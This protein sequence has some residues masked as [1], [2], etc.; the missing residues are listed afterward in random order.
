MEGPTV[1]NSIP[2]TNTYSRYRIPSSSTATTMT[3]A[4][5]ASEEEP[6]ADYKRSYTMDNFNQLGYFSSAD[7]IHP[8]L[9]PSAAIRDRYYQSTRYLQTHGDVDEEDTVYEEDTI[10][11]DILDYRPGQSEVCI[12]EP[13]VYSLNDSIISLHTE[14]NG[15]NND[16]ASSIT[17]IRTLDDRLQG[18]SRAS[19]LNQFAVK[20]AKK[21][22]RSGSLFR[23]NVDDK[24]LEPFVPVRD[25]FSRTDNSSS[26]TMGGMSLL[27]KLSKSTAPMRAKLSAISSFSSKN[28]LTG[29]KRMAESVYNMPVSVPSSIISRPLY[30]TR[31]NSDKSSI[32]HFPRSLSAS[33][34]TSSTSTANMIVSSAL[35]EEPMPIL[36]EHF[37]KIYP[38]FLSKVAEAFR[39]A[40]ELSTKTKDGIKYT[41][42][43]DGK[44]AVDKLSGLIKSNDRNLAILLGRALDSQKFFHDVNYEHR[45]RDSS[46][47]IYCFQE[48]IG[49]FVPS[50]AKEEEVLALPTGVFTLLTDCYSP[51]CTRE[52]LCYSSR[53]PRRQEQTKH[54]RRGHSREGSFSHLVMH[55]ERL[56]IHDVPVEILDTLSKDEKK[57]QENIFEL[58][59]TESDFVEDM[60]YILDYWVDPLL[61]EA[62]P[63]T[64][65]RQRLVETIFWN[66]NQVYTVNHRFSQALL[67]RQAESKVVD[68]IG[69]LLL[70]H[71]DFFEPFVRY[72]AHQLIGKYAFETEKSTNPSFADFVNQ[73]ERLPQSR[74]LELNG[75][76]TKPTTRLGRYNL[77]LREI[78]K[79]TA[80]AHPDQKYIPEVM[81][82]ITKFLSDVNR[83]TGVTENKFE[84]ERLDKRLVNRHISNLDLDLL[85]ENRQIVMK[86]TWKKGSGS[87]SSDVIVYLLDHCLLILKPKQNEER[88]KLYRKPIPLALLSISFPDQ[89]KRGSTI[90]TLGRPSTASSAGSIE[91]SQSHSSIVSTAASVIHQSSKS[92]FPVSFV[93]LGRQSSGSMTLYAPSSTVRKQ[94]S[95]KIEGQRKV[96]VEK[97]RVFNIKSINHSFFSSFNKVNCIAVFDNGQSFVL[98]GDQ[99]V[100]LKK[101]GDLGDSL[102]RI[103]TMEKVSQIDVLEQSN[104]ILVLADKILY[105]YSLDTLLPTETGMKRGRKLSS[106]VSFF[107]VGKIWDKSAAAMASTEEEKDDINGIE[108]TLVCFVRYSAMTSTI[109]ALE[110]CENTESKK[111]HKNLNRL[112]RGNNEALKVYKDLYIPGEASS[113][114]FFKNIICV[115]SARG[116]QM[117]NLSSA[118][119]QSVLDPND[120]NNNSLLAQHEYIKPISMFRHKNGDILLCYNELAFYID[121]KGKRVRKDWCITWEGHPTAFCFKFPYVVAFN[122]NFIEVR[123]IDTGDLLQVISGTN[124]RC[125][126]PDSTEIIH[127]VMDDRVG[128]NE[129]VF[130]LDLFEASRRK[131]S[132]IKN[133]Q[134]A[135]RQH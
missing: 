18:K 97:H 42:V 80:K 16:D 122:T 76:L 13:S 21:V 54:V 96:L 37:Y 7:I 49:A 11:G 24:K 85:S 27:S 65:D 73:T 86:G 81:A 130:E 133:V 95:D 53:C 35:V 34:S 72:G 38:A 94:W 36:R 101:G 9:T 113:I 125:L 43:F 66:L 119:V 107:K 99:G 41:N 129:V 123:H 14:Y 102:T 88:Y 98:G 56:W 128:G 100:Y 74:K 68:K 48:N 31:I 39:D 92:G 52:K 6:T 134:R 67:E 114:Q 32:H 79:H 71:V 2:S 131:Q 15:S 46:Q 57:R 83:E 28:N 69:D 93:H 23:R 121:K 1:K 51:T 40:I 77:L 8:E 132:M 90:I 135:I 89:N 106:H 109:R 117:V 45:L 20:T 126:R 33:S 111:K 25:S 55:E 127:G 84:L 70:S 4:S 87:E 108:R 63:V 26:K 104:L 82:K 5:F 64:G 44:E 110:P 120:D 58:I 78:L 22:S 19:Q 115:G 62:S 60:K 105:T 30:P 12:K 29:R 116:F 118:E 103:L 112:I 59:Y 61:D 10:S 91:S 124:I 75:Y 47:E 50:E 17:S 3:S